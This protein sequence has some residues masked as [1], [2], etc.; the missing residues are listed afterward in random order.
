MDDKYKQKYHSH[1]AVTG[2]F[3][4]DKVK[5]G[6]LTAY[7]RYGCRCESCKKANCYSANKYRKIS[8]GL[9]TAIPKPK[10]HPECGESSGY[11]AG[12][13]CQACKESARVCREK[14]INKAKAYFAETGEF[15]TAKTKHGTKTAYNLYGCR[16]VQCRAANVQ[17][18][19]K[20]RAKRAKELKNK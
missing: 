12:C 18:S 8:K 16:C 14:T 10:K 5:H 3:L 13:R 7:K 15:L 2:Q 1:F 6:T 4:S 11:N 20:S 17:S 19:L 9:L